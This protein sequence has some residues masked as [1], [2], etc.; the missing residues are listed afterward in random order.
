MRRNFSASAARL[1]NVGTSSRARE[2]S[3]APLAVNAVIVSDIRSCIQ[4]SLLRGLGFVYFKGSENS[5]Y[6]SKLTSGGRAALRCGFVWRR[7]IWD[8]RNADHLKPEHL[9]LNPN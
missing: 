2:R 5:I 4:V 1:R 6:S 7:R 3:S 8:S 9:K